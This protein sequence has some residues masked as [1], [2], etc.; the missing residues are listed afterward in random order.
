[1]TGFGSS[2]PLDGL[3]NPHLSEVSKE[4]HDESIFNC[5]NI[6]IL[7]LGTMGYNSIPIIRQDSRTE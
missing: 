6:L 7:R 3:S 1:M 2:S 4:I 5:F